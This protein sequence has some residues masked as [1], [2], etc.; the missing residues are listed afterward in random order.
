MA[1]RDMEPEPAS[2]WRFQYPAM[3]AGCLGPLANFRL[4]VCVCER[5]SVCAITCYYLVASSHASAI[6]NKMLSVVPVVFVCLQFL[7]VTAFCLQV[8]FGFSPN[9]ASKDC[10]CLNFKIKVCLRVGHVTRDFQVRPIVHELTTALYHL[11]SIGIAGTSTLPARYLYGDHLIQ[12]T[13]NVTTS[14]FLGGHVVSGPDNCRNGC[15]VPPL[16]QKGGL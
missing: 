12:G 6:T 7:Q 4:P 1:H 16:H 8:A 11:I 3:K 9:A 14:S 15:R 13:R 2:Y 10:F 5:E